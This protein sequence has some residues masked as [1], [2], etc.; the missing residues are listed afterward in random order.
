[1]FFT[2]IIIRVLLSPTLNK[3]IRSLIKN[4]PVSQIFSSKHTFLPSFSHI[5][6]IFLPS[7][8]RIFS[9]PCIAQAKG[10]CE[11]TLAYPALYTAMPRVSTGHAPRGCQTLGK[12]TTVLCW[13]SS[14]NHAMSFVFIYLQIQILN[15]HLIKILDLPTISNQHCTCKI[16][17]ML[18]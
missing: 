14:W 12:S 15:F 16:N 13:S 18:L 10:S 7:F 1:M 11:R 3:I 2:L 6:L 5:S 8:S 9:H 17:L 4:A